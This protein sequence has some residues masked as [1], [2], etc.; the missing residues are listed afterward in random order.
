MIKM[1]SCVLLIFLFA[2]KEN[3]A[4]CGTAN[5][6]LHINNPVLK[7]LFFFGLSHEYIHQDQIFVGSNR[8]FVGAIPQHHDEV[9]TVNQITNFSLGYS[10]TDYLT[11]N[12]NLPYIQRKH[13]HIHN[14]HGEMIRQSWNFN[15]PGDLNLN[16][17][18]ALLKND[19]TRSELYFNAGIKIPTGVTDVK[20]SEGEE[21][22]VT[23]QPGSGSV[24]YLVGAIYTQN[25]ASIPFISGSG[26]SELPLILNINYR[27]NNKGTDNYKF[28]NA[29]YIHLSTAYRFIEKLSFLIQLNLKFQDK[30]NVGITNEPEGNTG[31]QWLFLSP[32]LKFHIFNNLSIASYIQIPLYQNFNGIQQ[33]APY[34][35]QFSV[36]Q[37]FDFL[38]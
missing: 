11:F 4:S 38:D 36:Q 12:L 24:D 34:N 3:P 10:F 2:S 1:F 31:G 23:L 7:G 28:G 32:G 6:P 27:I 33:A 26:F 5:C 21:A 35:L 20:N 18:L 16:S 37:E 9:S 30:A 8:S 15:A 13:T 25:L 22:E 19:E 17:S 14:H 29:L